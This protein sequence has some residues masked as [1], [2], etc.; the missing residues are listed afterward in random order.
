MAKFQINGQELELDLA[1]A[2]MAERA[3]TAIQKVK[4]EAT[5]KEQEVKSLAGSIRATCAL[6]NECFDD[7]FGEG[8]SNQLFGEKKN[9]IISIDA[10]SA[11]GEE[12]KRQTEEI[13][14]HT[15][16]LAAKYSPNRAERRHS[17]P[18]AKK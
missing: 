12:I 17:A 5:A 9:M 8:T 3:Q 13:G 7:V 18:A 10:F 15:Q 16:D 6:V 1:D 11:L 14:Q 2:D 4:D